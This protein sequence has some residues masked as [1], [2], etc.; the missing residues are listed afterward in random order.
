MPPTRPSQGTPYHMHMIGHHAVSSHL[1]VPAEA[2]LRHQAEVCLI[3]LFTEKS[4][5]PTIRAIRP[6]QQRYSGVSTTSGITYGVPG[7][8]NLPRPV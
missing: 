2:P 4:R 7:I 3:V 5:L 6:M 8:W 1:H